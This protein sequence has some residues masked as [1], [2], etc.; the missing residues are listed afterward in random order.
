MVQVSDHLTSASV[1]GRSNIL[2]Q[3]SP[4]S[5]LL[6]FYLLSRLDFTSPVQR[7]QHMD[8]LYLASYFSSVQYRVHYLMLW[9]EPPL[10][11]WSEI[12]KPHSWEALV[13]CWIL[14]LKQIHNS[15]PWGICNRRPVS[16][17]VFKCPSL[18]DDNSCLWTVI[19]HPEENWHVY[20]IRW[21][22]NGGVF[23]QY[24]LS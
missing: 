8:T 21:Y 3:Y 6:Y 12:G 19:S 22:E 20:P 2:P 15:T 11:G 24:I 14:F 10:K 1:P 4:D 13:N 9:H 23:N 5:S 16:K 7:E 17:I 18:P